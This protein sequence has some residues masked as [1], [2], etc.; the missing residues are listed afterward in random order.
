[1]K[2][3]IKFSK[4]GAMKFI[5]HLDIMR[6]FQKA[7][8]RAGIDI[9]YTEGFS[10][11]MVM[12]FASPLG[13]GLT[14]DAEY[15]DIE[16]HSAISSKEAL[17][18]LNA[19][20]AEGIEVLSFRKIP[21]EKASNAMSLVAAAD[22]RIS[23]REGMEPFE[24][25]EERWQAFWAQKEIVITKKTK[26]SEKE[27]DIRPYLYEA[28]ILDHAVFLKLCA[29]SAVNIK[30]E[31]VMQAFAEQNGAVWNPLSILVHRM[32]L[33]T[34]RGAE[35]EKNFVSLEDLGEDIAQ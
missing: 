4:H 27:M 31:L 23:F 5:G 8:R 19:A 1:M 6:Y 17:R 34:D 30:P 11:H 16:I 26:K 28:K 15:F 25:W 12:S 18:R 21:Q 20:M 22:Y 3:R 32:E 7:I 13:V 10:P 29:G 9:V 2:I 35:G 33:Y 14:S 24:N